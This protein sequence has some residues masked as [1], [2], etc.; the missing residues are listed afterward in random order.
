MSLHPG[1]TFSSWSSSPF[2][3][4]E[5]ALSHQLHIPAPVSLAS[6]P[7]AL[8]LKLPAWNFPSPVSIPP[9]PCLLPSLPSARHH[10]ASPCL[11]RSCPHSPSPHLSLLTHALLH[12]PLTPSPA[13]ASNRHP[14]SSLPHTLQG[15]SSP[16]LPNLP[17]NSHS[18]RYKPNCAN[19]QLP[20]HLQNPFLHPCPGRVGVG[21]AAL[22]LSL[23]EAELV[24]AWGATGA[25]DSVLPHWAAQASHPSPRACFLTR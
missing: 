10:W 14:S 15:G 9:P 19:T 17:P 23:A 3:L 24:G 20:W 8:P 7:P 22:A 13:A 18:C 21:A 5:S 11:P 6:V 4:E 25:T 12:H 16:C 2:L 1:P